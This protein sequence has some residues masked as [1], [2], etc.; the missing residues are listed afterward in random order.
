M[1]RLAP[2]DLVLRAG[3]THTAVDTLLQRL[4]QV[5]P[6]FQAHAEERGLAMPLV[7]LARAHSSKPK[8]PFGGEV[9]DLAAGNCATTVEQLRREGVLVLGG[10]PSAVLKRWQRPR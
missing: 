9:V 1:A 5:L 10:T 7:R 4:Q 8:A 3:N 6:W 2:G